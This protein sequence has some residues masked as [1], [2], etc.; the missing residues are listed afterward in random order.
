MPQ[1]QQT[2]TEYE[3]LPYC[4]ALTRYF[5]TVTE[6]PD[7]VLF[8]QLRRAEERVA[9]V[10][11]QPLQPYQRGALVCLVSDVLYGLA[12]CPS[13]PFEKSFLVSAL[14]K[15]M[16]QIAAAEFFMFCHVN[17]KVQTRAWEKRRAEQ[18]S[19]QP[20]APPV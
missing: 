15:G 17:G 6:R 20:G 5:Y 3:P 16:L 10:I 14:N 4:V 1:L 19:V 2:I 13:V 18:D 11:V 9:K 7:V 12:S 8:R